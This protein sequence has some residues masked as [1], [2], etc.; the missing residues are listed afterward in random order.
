[1]SSPKPWTC[2]K[3]STPNSSSRP[4]CQ[5]FIHPCAT[6]FTNSSNSIKKPCT[7]W[8]CPTCLIPR[9]PTSLPHPAPQ[10]INSLRHHPDRP[11]QHPQPSQPQ[12]AT[13]EQQPQ[14][15]HRF[16]YTAA[17]LQSAASRPGT[18]TF[19]EAF[20]AQGQAA[21]MGV[22]EPPVVSLAGL[23]LDYSTG[24]KNGYPDGGMN[25]NG[26]GGGLCG[27]L[28]A[29]EPGE[30]HREE[31][32]GHWR[33]VGGRERAG[34][35]CLEVDSWEW[36]DDW[37][38]GWQV[39]KKCCGEAGGLRAAGRKRKAEMD[40]GRERV[41]AESGQGNNKRRDKGRE[42]K[43]REKGR[44]RAKEKGKG[45]AKAA[46]CGWAPVRCPPQPAPAP[47]PLPVGYQPASVEDGSDGEEIGVYAHGGGNGVG[48]DEEW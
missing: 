45:K 6:H 41:A 36:G 34:D 37:G 8:H 30:E 14:P 43:E 9:L 44:A 42:S 33:G 11:L 32:G 27:I 31:S 1:M 40:R 24:G 38:P 25:V 13:H 20:P 28:A 19:A 21:G 46:A 17:Y 29:D 4:A 2:C 22:S 16:S 39:D 18:V 47:P 5:G 10:H 23:R 35:G 48:M 15:P 12:K 3:C 26:N 7:H